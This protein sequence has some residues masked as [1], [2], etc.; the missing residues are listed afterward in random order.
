MKPREGIMQN[1]LIGSDL[2]LS[3]MSPPL[4]KGH[5]TTPG[6]QRGARH[7]NSHG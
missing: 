4:I 5:C 1:V 3:G 6:G 7:S 2:Q